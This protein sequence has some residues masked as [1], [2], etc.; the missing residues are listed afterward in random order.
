MIRL[1]TK[2]AEDTQALA[3][4]LSM[5]ARPGDVVLVAGDIGAGKTV[6]VQGFGRGLEV[7]EPITSPTFTLVRGYQG[8]IPLVHVDVYRLDH[9][10]EVED[11]G[12]AE[13]L[14]EGAVAVVEWG[15]VV[16]PVLPADF[17][18]VRLEPGGGEDER[19]VRLRTVG[20]RWSARQAAVR[21]AAERWLAEED[22][23]C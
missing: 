4:E 20:A 17:L 8:R 14:D 6:F 11:L 15:D 2:S 19:L 21:R 5:V 22:T 1:R 7:D 10:Q 13:L 9:L 16:A 12:L 18:E 23:P 3:S